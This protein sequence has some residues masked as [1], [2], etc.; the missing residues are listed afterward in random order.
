MKANED[1]ARRL[2]G[3]VLHVVARFDVD[4]PTFGIESHLAPQTAGKVAATLPV[5]IDVFASTQRP[6]VPDTMLQNLARARKDLGQR[7]IGA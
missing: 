2:P 4:L 1:T 6:Q 7:L 3:D 5:E